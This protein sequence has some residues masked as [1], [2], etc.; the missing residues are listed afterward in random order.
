MYVISFDHTK[1]NSEVKKLQ[2]LY[3]RKT[4]SFSVNSFLYVNALDLHL[5][6]M[7]RG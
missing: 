6:G 7:I 5:R 2:V 1:S 4:N 3:M